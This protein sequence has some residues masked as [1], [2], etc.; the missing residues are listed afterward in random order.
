MSVDE[1]F[2]SD[3]DELN[4][5]DELDFEMSDFVVPADEEDDEPNDVLFALNWI[6][7]EDYDYIHEIIII[8]NLNL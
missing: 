2:E 3:V 4:E 6:I 7:F 8:T 1:F 5:P